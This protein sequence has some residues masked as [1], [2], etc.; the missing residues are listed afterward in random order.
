MRYKEEILFLQ[1]EHR[2]TLVSLEKTAQTW[3][4]RSQLDAEVFPCDIL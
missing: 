1:E 3:D 2:R 4:G